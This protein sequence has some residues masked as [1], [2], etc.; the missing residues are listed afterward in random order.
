MVKDIR[1]IL[2]VC[3][4]ASVAYRN[5]GQWVGKVRPGI[6]DATR[7]RDKVQTRRL[8]QLAHVVFILHSYL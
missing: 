5:L 1:R 8:A 2:V 3:W 4:Q 6:R 7:T